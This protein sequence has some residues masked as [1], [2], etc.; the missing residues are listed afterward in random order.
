MDVHGFLRLMRERQSIEHLRA[1]IIAAINARR[2]GVGPPSAWVFPS[3]RPRYS[4]DGI[5]RRNTNA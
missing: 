2:D 4:A 5:D 3:L 1:H